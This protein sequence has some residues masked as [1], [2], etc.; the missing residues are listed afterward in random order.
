MGLYS[1]YSAD[2][3][4]QFPYYTS[5]QT[6][7][8]Q[9]V[10]NI[11]SEDSYS[12]V[13]WNTYY[14]KRYKALNSILYFIMLICVIIIVLTIIKKSV[15]FFDDN[16]YSVVVGIILALSVIYIVRQLWSIMFRDNKNFDEYAYTFNTNANTIGNDTIHNNIMSDCVST[17][18]KP[19][20]NYSSITN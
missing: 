1:D 15:P 7:F 20:V 2:V 6:A 3:S 13:K 10:Q 14:Y 9:D 19:Q 17:T 18:P 12:S 4:F 5:K 11:L 16:A 8:Y